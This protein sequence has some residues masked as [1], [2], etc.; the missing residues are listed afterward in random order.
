MTKTFPGPIVRDEEL[1]IRDS[2]TEA[3]YVIEDSISLDVF[4]LTSPEDMRRIAGLL[5]DAAAVIEANDE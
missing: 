1:L 4:G 2:N 3:D 5:D